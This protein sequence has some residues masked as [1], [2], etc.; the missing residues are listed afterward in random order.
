MYHGS[1]SI[2]KSSNQ[3]RRIG[4]IDHSF[5]VLLIMVIVD[6]QSEVLHTIYI[7]IIDPFKSI[8]CHEIYILHF[9]SDLRIVYEVLHTIYIMIIVDYQ[10]EVPYTICKSDLKCRI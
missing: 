7:M 4:V 10:F 1:G 9:K 6:Y 3:S 8:V 5:Q 2:K